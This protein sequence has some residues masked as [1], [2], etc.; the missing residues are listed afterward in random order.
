MPTAGQP[1]F[2]QCEAMQDGVLYR[3]VSDDN[4]RGVSVL[5]RW[6]TDDHAKF[7][8]L[9]REMQSQFGTPQEG[10]TSDGVRVLEWRLEGYFWHLARSPGDRSITREAAVDSIATLPPC[11]SG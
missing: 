6:N 4:G 8:S 7:S 3:V 5:M 9:R 2:H 11:A 1:P 10:C